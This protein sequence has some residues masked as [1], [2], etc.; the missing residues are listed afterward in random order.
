M[1]AGLAAAT[2]TI[3]GFATVVWAEAPITSPVPAARP[4]LPVAQPAGLAAALPALPAELVALIHDA[5]LAIAA[6]KA[7][8]LSSFD[9]DTG[10]GVEWRVTAV[11]PR[12]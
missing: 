6:S 12:W 5:G 7:G 8:G 1:K 10:G 11:Q 4:A 3:L 9:T 2:L